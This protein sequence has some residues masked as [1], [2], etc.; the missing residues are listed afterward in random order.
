MLFWSTLDKKQRKVI[1]GKEREVLDS[2]G[3]QNKTKQNKIKQTDKGKKEKKRLS[4]KSN[5]IL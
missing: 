3:K 1:K 4:S 2:E 5:K